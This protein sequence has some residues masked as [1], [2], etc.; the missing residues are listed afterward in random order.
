MNRYLLRC[1]VIFVARLELRVR[2][3]VR[4]F[5]RLVCVLFC[6][7]F[8][9]HLCFFF[10]LG[11]SLP[12]PK[13]IFPPGFPWPWFADLQ[14][15][16]HAGSLLC[17]YYWKAYFARTSLNAVYALPST[18]IDGTIAFNLKIRRRSRILPSF[19][20]EKCNELYDYVAKGCRN[21]FC[22]CWV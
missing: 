17:R 15:F 6:G 8:L 14:C 1:D 21:S 7:G 10:L 22:G 18:S 4:L 13:A 20:E 3:F 12:C 5:A 11:K 2:G 16:L 19:I 9:R